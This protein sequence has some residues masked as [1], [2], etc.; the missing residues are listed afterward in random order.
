MFHDYLSVSYCLST[1]ARGVSMC[2]WLLS[3]A[4]ASV[5]RRSLIRNPTIDPACY[6]RVAASTG[7]AQLHGSDFHNENLL[8]MLVTSHLTAFRQV[9]SSVPTGP[10][11]ILSWGSFG[12]EHSAVYFVLAALQKAL[13]GEVKF[14]LTMQVNAPDSMQKWNAM[15]SSV[16]HAGGVVLVFGYILN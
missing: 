16:T 2:L 10:P 3:H 8:D 6:A 1:Q 13:P 5:K 14:D 15:M 7:S 4:M 12:R 11:A 9:M